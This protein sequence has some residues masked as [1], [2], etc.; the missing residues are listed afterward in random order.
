MTKTILNRCTF[1]FKYEYN[2]KKNY[3]IFDDAFLK[4]LNS[5]L[6]CLWRI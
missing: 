6:C 3:H 4:V 2:E 1:L 5:L